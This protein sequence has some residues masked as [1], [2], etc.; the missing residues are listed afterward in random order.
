MKILFIFSILVLLTSCE[1]VLKNAD[2]LT[3]IAIAND[4]IQSGQVGIV[5]KSAPLSDTERLMVDH[6]VNEYM[7]FAR[8][9][10]TS[11]ID[12][13]STATIFPTFLTEYNDLVAQYRA[14]ENVVSAHWSD[15]S[16]INQ[17]RLLNY[18]AR[19]E[20]INSSIDGLIDAGMRHQAIID[21]ITFAGILAG[22][23]LRP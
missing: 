14:V 8:R 23:A 18:K 7:A 11:M 15:Y 21:A 3:N 1:T 2:D 5:I 13:D 20:K 17:S 12:I 9:W 19:A 16:S 4:Q 10:K 6:A 22:V